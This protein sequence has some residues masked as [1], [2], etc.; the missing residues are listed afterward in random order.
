MEKKEESGKVVEA[1]LKE[2]SPPKHIEKTLEN[3]K[4]DTRFTLDDV[5]Y[6]IEENQR[7]FQKGVEHGLSLKDEALKLERDKSEKSKQ[8]SWW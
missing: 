3:A 1:P 2:V 5:K 8:A 4:A 6:L 7:A